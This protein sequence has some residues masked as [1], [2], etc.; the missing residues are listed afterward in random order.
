MIRVSGV[1]WFTNLDIIKRHEDLTL[2]K[3]YNPKDYPKY[4]NYDAINID[5]T[6]D[7]PIDYKG[8][9]GVPITF[10]N[11]YNPNQFEILVYLKVGYGLKSKKFY[12]EFKETRQDG[13]LTGGSGKKRQSCFER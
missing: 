1:V 9:M 10:L 11:K 12:D 2:Y 7:I 6:N 8:V 13:S 4:D 3:K 5:K